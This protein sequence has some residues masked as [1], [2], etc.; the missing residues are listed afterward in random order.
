MNPLVAPNVEGVNSERRAG[1]S[2]VMLL[3]DEFERALIEDTDNRARNQDNWKLYAGI[4]FQQWS[5]QSLADAL[6]EGRYL[7]T[8]NICTHKVDSL[9]GA[10]LK[11][12]F[13]SDF[14][15]VE[16]ADAKQTYLAKQKYLSDKDVTDW[17]ASEE[18][19]VLG[20]LVYEGVEEIYIDRKVDPQGT[21]GFR[22]NLPGHVIFD[23]N[24][25]TK[26]AKDC[27]KA[28]KAVYLLPSQIAALWP[29]ARP[30]LSPQLTSQIAFGEM[31]DSTARGVLPHFD[32]IEGDGDLIKVILCYRMKEEKYFEEYDEMTGL[33]LPNT[34][35]LTVKIAFLNRTND[36]WSPT[37]VKQRP[38]TRLAC[39]RTDIMPDI[40]L[41]RPLS[42]K[43]TETQVGR[44]PFFPWAASRINGVPR[45]IIDLIR[46]IQRNI[47]SREAWLDYI[48]QTQSN[49]G[50]LYDPQLFNNDQT[51]IDQF[52]NMSNNPG[53]KIK[54]APG[55]LKRIGAP[56]PIAKNDYPSET[57][58]QL[59]RMWDY[60]DRI[61][62][63]PAVADA[64]TE[65]AGE[66]GYMFAQKQTLM[67]LQQ[68]ILFSGLKRHKGEKGEA[69]LEQARIQYSLGGHQRSFM[70][71]DRKTVMY[72]N[73]R[74][75]G[76]D[77]SERV[78]ND[79]SQLPRHKFN[80][81]ESPSGATARLI[82]RALST[83][84]LKVI[85]KES[86]GTRA[87]L[88]TTISGTL[89]HLDGETREN[90]KEMGK[91]EVEQAKEGMLSNIAEFK[92]KRAQATVQTKNTLNPP[93]PGPA[94]AQGAGGGQPP[95]AP[96]AGPPP[97]PGQP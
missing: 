35:D 34:T 40:M 28:Y 20:G 53:A 25:K 80:V 70:A 82:S 66:P 84:T 13:D 38:R 75:K 79:L 67:S 18:D 3:N 47:N 76:S 96:P 51:L 9:A 54:T 15:P 12:P 71:E 10:I 94:L 73:Q 11:N 97:S 63:S 91:I 61:S 26:S 72:L 87:L 62:K 16:A 24:W 5:A 64:R 86:A 31:F 46:D 57:Q 7:N 77:G 68:H 17:D 8:Y 69:W 92:L 42:E 30:Y 29:D 65:H 55:A 6:M 93:P 36:R 50:M 58:N 33:T 49:P 90:I 22:T 45:G 88:G 1:Y 52:I 2:K 81:T 41:E 44:L 23:P 95:A 56:Q 27:M 48:I 85:P 4:D 78:T 59:S 14:A 89:D 60:A 83:E 32:L 21:I 37:K 39:Y 19:L 74:V 43:R